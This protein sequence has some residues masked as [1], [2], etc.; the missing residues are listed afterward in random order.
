VIVPLVQFDFKCSTNLKLGSDSVGYTPSNY[1]QDK[2][3]VADENI[4]IFIGG[5]QG[6]IRMAQVGKCGRLSAETGEL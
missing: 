2:G 3:D 1:V 5:K 6:Q 4:R